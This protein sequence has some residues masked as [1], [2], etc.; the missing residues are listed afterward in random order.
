MEP[1]F[2][3]YTLPKLSDEASLRRVQEFRAS[4]DTRRS[5][6]QFS[7]DP[8]SRAVIEEV[9]AAAGTAP[10]G[11]HKQP[12]TFVA[13]SDPALKQ[14]IRDVAE[15]EERRFYGELAPQQWLDDLAPLGTDWHKTHLTDAPWLIV[16]FAQEYAMRD[17]G[18]KG[19]HY[20]VNESVGIAVGF[21][22][23]AIRQAGLASLTHTPSPMAFLRTELGRPAN[24][25]AYVVIPVGYPAPGCKVPDL[26]RKP[27]DQFTVWK[28]APA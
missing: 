6:R 5:V 1:R 15:E 23:A 12:W 18:S 25:R 14:R 13:I 19:K 11:A 4:L 10:S 2:V 3:P 16:V 20:Y 27:L 22:L 7:R 28:E 26:K 17:D 9:L 21:L 24:E 8:V